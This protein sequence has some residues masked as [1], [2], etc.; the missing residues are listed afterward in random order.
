MWS[1]MYTRGA[2]GRRVGFLM[3]HGH[4]RVRRLICNRAR[5]ASILSLTRKSGRSSKSRL[6]P[7]PI[8]FK[9]H[10]TSELGGSELLAAY[11]AL[12]SLHNVIPFEETE[13]TADDGT[14]D[15]AEVVDELIKMMKEQAEGP[16]V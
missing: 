6:T 4:Y 14:K 2:P 15:L 7:T 11:Q 8:M 16:Q 10:K 1:L 9:K 3:S 12:E 5:A 13:T